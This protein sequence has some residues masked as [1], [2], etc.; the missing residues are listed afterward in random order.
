MNVLICGDSYSDETYVINKYKPTHTWVTLLRQDFE[1]NCVAVAG[2]TNVEIL[3]Q[4]LKHRQPW[5][6]DAT[7]VSLAPIA[8]GDN[9]KNSLAAIRKI[10]RLKNTYVWSSFTDFKNTKD[11][12]W[13]PFVAYNELH[14]KE[15]YNKEY[16]RRDFLF[17]GCHFTRAGNDA[18]YKHMKY[19]LE[20]RSFK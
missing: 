15:Q 2:A 17:T 14:I 3:S 20:N 8:R 4:V 11:I 1:V 9:T 5:P 12:D 6:N 19:I 16:E 10:I 7:I 18:V 13:L